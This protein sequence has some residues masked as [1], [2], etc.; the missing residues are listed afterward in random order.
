MGRII[1]GTAMKPI[2]IV[3]ATREGHTHPAAEH[4]ARAIRADE[5]DTH[6]HHAGRRL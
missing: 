4:I 1:G 3:Y 6:I 5:L 2:L